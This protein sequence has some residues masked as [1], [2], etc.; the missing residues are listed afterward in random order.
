MDDIDH[1]DV[2]G[3]VQRMEIGMP[4][5]TFTSDITDFEII[6]FDKSFVRISIAWLDISRIDTYCGCYRFENR[7]RLVEGSD[8]V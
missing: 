1:T 3:P 5:D 6:N 7:S 8:G 4:T 2:T